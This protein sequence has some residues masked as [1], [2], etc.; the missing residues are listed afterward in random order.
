MTDT[1]KPE[2]KAPSA[3]PAPKPEVKAPSAKPAPKPEVKAPSAK[4]ATKP[5]VKTP[6]AK[7]APK[8]VAKAPSAKPAPKPVA[9][10]PSAKPV[11]KPAPKPV[12]KTPSAKPAPKPV[13]K[14]PSAKPA[15][16]SVKANTT[17]TDVKVT[18][19][20]NV[21]T[22]KKN[23]NAT[24]TVSLSH[25]FFEEHKLDNI[26]KEQ[27]SKIIDVLSKTKTLPPSSCM[28]IFYVEYNNKSYELQRGEPIIVS[29]TQNQKAYSIFVNFLL[30]KD[31][32][33]FY[34]HISRMRCNACS[35]KSTHRQKIHKCMLNINSNTCLD[36]FVRATLGLCINTQQENQ[37]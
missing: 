1:K 27:A 23:I 35:S 9:K 22:N 7:P 25:D 5:E 29:D 34:C 37:K 2:T 13:A 31:H 17:K 28:N 3:K 21:E 8:P 33:E 32:M 16:E 36:R 14:A 24:I 11:A 10:A 4:P 20:T 26:T 12:T 15:P 19:N 30:L 6:S 18:E